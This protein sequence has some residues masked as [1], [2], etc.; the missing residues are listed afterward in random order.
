MIGLAQQRRNAKMGLHYATH[1]DKMSWSGLEFFPAKNISEVIAATVAK[2]AKRKAVDMHGTRTD[3]E[4]HEGMEGVSP[5]LSYC[6][7]YEEAMHE[8][9][10]IISRLEW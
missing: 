3:P 5:Y 10:Q 2:I 8:L 9:S 4:Y 6:D 7:G 1:P